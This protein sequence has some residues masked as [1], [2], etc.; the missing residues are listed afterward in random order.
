[1]IEKN[2]F[3]NNTFLASGNGILEIT[4]NSQ[5]VRISNNQ[6]L[7]NKC[8]F[9]AKFTTWT[10]PS[11]TALELVNNI[12]EENIGLQQNLEEARYTNLTSFSLGIFGCY[13]RSY[14][15]DHNVFN[16][17]R[18]DAEL[19]IGSG[20]GTN[21]YHN[22]CQIDARFNWWGTSTV[23]EVK[24]RIFDFNDWNDRAKV[25]FLPAATSR[26]FSSFS[27]FVAAFGNLSFIGGYLNSSV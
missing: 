6:F 13:F 15:F 4:G 8:T 23:T 12:M 22:G 2:M 14:T 11:T 18:M 16:N 7:N 27:G 21:F 9:L 26:N 10:S 20:C 25:T 17:G 19:F 3:I 5:V 24:N 1:M